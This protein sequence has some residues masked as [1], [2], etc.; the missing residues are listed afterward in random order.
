M[1]PE[2]K[3]DVLRKLATALLNTIEAFPD[4]A[5]MGPCYLAFMQAG[6]SL[7][8]FAEVVQTLV[9]TGKVRRSGDL[10]FAV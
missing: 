2:Q 5:P 3:L 4:G 8:D 6:F 1:T 10:L 9:D 7:E